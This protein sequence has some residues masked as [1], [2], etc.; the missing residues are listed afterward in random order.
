M[1]IGLEYSGGEASMFVGIVTT[2]KDGYFFVG[3][4][5]SQQH[6]AVF[7]GPGYQLTDAISIFIG[8]ETSLQSNEIF[9]GLEYSELDST[10][11][12]FVGGF[13]D[14]HNWSYFLGILVYL[15]VLG[16]I[17]TSL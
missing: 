17:Q 1:F 10:D 14:G 15:D 11:S 7:A 6:E 5:K 9:I 8:L 16:L 12:L 13:Y 3:F 2:T 4:D